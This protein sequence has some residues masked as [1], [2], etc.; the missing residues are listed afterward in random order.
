M[1]FAIGLDPFP[2]I[3]VAA[4]YPGLVVLVPDAAWWLLESLLAVG[5]SWRRMK[6]RSAATVVWL[7]V[8]WLLASG[9]RFTPQILARTT[10]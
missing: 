7:A 5:L 6:P 4:Q 2:A 1:R 8:V 3:P 10:H 9:A